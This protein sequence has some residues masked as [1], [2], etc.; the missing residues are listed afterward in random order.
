MGCMHFQNRFNFLLLNLQMPSIVNNSDL[1]SVHSSAE[2]EK[3]RPWLMID[4]LIAGFLTSTAVVSFYHEAQFFTRST[5][6]KKPKAYF[7]FWG[8]HLFALG[9]LIHTFHGNVNIRSYYMILGGTL[10]AAVVNSTCLLSCWSIDIETPTHCCRCLQWISHR[11]VLFLSTIVLHAF[12][13]FTIAYAIPTIVLILYLNTIGTLLRLTIIANIILIVTTLLAF[14]IYQYERFCHLFAERKPKRYKPIFEERATNHDQYYS[15]QFPAKGKGFIGCYTY[16]YQPVGTIL[17]LVVFIFLIQIIF[18]LVKQTDYTKEYETQLLV[19][20]IP[21]VMFLFGYCYK[22][23]KL[24]HAEKKLLPD[25]LDTLEV[26]AA[27]R[28]SLEA[29]EPTQQRG[30]SPERLPPGSPERLPPGSPERLP[31][32]SPERLPPGSPERLPPG[33]PE[34]LPP[35]SP[36]RLPPGSPERLPPGSPERLPPGSPERLPPGSPERLPPGRP[37]RLPPGR[38]EP[39]PRESANAREHRR[40]DP[41]TRHGEGSK[42]P[43]TSV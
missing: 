31:P 18:E 11:V 20:I 1:T 24:L 6:G 38:P 26:P 15:S 30:G 16:I 34:R 10:V 27:I 42:E 25:T 35:G 22:L 13:L 2:D 40:P 5:A 9:L 33:S 21:S 37:E 4:I 39:P 36:E 14:L 7:L 12:L 41:L 32:G 8:F 19:A 3:V 17:A 23:R 29:P 28:R 43:E